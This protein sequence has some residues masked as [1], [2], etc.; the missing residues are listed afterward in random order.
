MH[1][2]LSPGFI[3]EWRDP[4]F[5][6]FSITFTLPLRQNVQQEGPDGIPWHSMT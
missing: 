5:I 3:D 6:V 4:V 1:T 2:T